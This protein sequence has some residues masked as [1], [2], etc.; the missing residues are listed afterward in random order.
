MVQG[1]ANAACGGDSDAH[2]MATIDSVNQVQLVG[3]PAA[4]PVANLTPK[5]PS[6][7]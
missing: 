1:T 4:G 2:S 7:C 3:A 6:K 5:P